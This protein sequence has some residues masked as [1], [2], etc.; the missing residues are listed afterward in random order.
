MAYIY[1]SIKLC[2]Q[3]Y[4]KLQHFAGQTIPGKLATREKT[5][6]E[7]EDS[8]RLGVLQLV[9][10]VI[11]LYRNKKNVRWRVIQQSWH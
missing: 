10:E 4:K 5:S 9:Q 3:P 1:A 7:D 6:L 8:F 2:L 11:L